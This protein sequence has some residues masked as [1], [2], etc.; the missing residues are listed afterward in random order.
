[1]IKV[2]QNKGKCG[3]DINGNIIEL[4][5]DTACILRS[6]Y[7]AIHEGNHEAAEEYARLVVRL[8]IDP[9]SDVFE[10]NEKEE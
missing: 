8:I 7:S 2:N 1:M 10:P 4:A 3:I 9:D 5:L 6:I